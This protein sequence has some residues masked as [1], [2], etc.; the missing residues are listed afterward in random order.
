MIKGFVV[1][2][3]C[4]GNIKSKMMHFLNL[5]MLFKQYKMLE[6]AVVN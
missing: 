4:Y 5:N 6:R 1:I 3:E 2:S